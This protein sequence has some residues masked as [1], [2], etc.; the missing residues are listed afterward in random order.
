MAN[1]VLGVGY[2]LVS[3][4]DYGLRT[5]GNRLDEAEKL[6]M[7]FVE[8]PL[9]ALDVIAGGKIL[10]GRLKTVKSMLAG[11][12]LRY[13]IHG[14]LA[15]NF[16]DVP[17]RL[18]RHKEVLRVSLDASAELEGLHYVLHSG[19]HAAGGQAET[20]RLHAQQRDLISGFGEQAA[21]LGLIIVVENLFVEQAPRATA[22]PSRLAREI[23]AIAHPNVWACLDFS[24]GFIYSTA[25]GANFEAEVAALAPFARHLHIHDSFGQPA[26]TPTYHRGE[27][28][29]Y[30]EG[31]LHLPPGLGGIPWDEL[32]QRLEFPGGVVFNLELA[33]PYWADLESAVATTRRLAG[34]ART[35]GS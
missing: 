31:D 5:L 22:L 33:P 1:N 35:A 16:M 30:G 10:A 7:D 6:G 28:L 26:V 2:T 25:K 11:R 12:G 4:D 24:H 18:E 17:E 23:A 14:P 34:Q 27:R 21:G 19:I 15:I 3:E 20:D 32:M 8:I 13:T 29:A 9:W